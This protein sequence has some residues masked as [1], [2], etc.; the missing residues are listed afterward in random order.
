M[1]ATNIKMEASLVYLGDASRFSKRYLL[2]YGEWPR[3]NQVM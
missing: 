1:G 3:E 2:A